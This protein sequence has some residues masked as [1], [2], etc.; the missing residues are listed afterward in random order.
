MKLL[1]FA[2]ASIVD[3]NTG[4]GL[5]HDVRNIHSADHISNGRTIRARSILDTLKLIKDQLAGS[6]SSLRAHIRSQGQLAVLARLDDHLLRDIGISREDIYA[7]Q[8]GLI[9][10]EQF[11]A[12]RDKTNR[13]SGLE[14]VR[15]S[16]P[17]TKLLQ[18]EAINE[19]VFSEAK[20]A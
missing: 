13:Y 12:K 20:C 9:S 19:A 1:Q 15:D 7:A 6:V 3:A 14:V 18:S 17:D 5:V 11:K 8:S 4:Q 16:Q 2:V 10:M